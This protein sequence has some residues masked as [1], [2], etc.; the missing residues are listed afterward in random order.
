[1][2]GGGGCR[3]TKEGNRGQVKRA[4]WRSPF[5]AC[6]GST[7]GWGWTS[8]TN[9]DA[10]AGQEST[11]PEC[12]RLMGQDVKRSQAHHCLKAT[13]TRVTSD[14]GPRR[15]LGKGGCHLSPLHSTQVFGRSV[16]WGRG[17]SRNGSLNS[18]AAF[19]STLP[20]INCP[21]TS[22]IAKKGN[23]KTLV[24]SPF[25]HSSTAT[26]LALCWVAEGRGWR[27]GGS[28]PY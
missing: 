26:L 3:R 13:P 1:M 21:K 19:Y 22:S 16:L 9:P 27:G 17:Q 2:F 15:W 8:K 20:R 14:G 28:G 10:R 7:G 24:A 5:Q 23:Y 4:A 11:K 18:A 12:G 6:W 25:P